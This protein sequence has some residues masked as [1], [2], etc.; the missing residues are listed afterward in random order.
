MKI[1]YRRYSRNRVPLYKNR[2]YGN[3]PVY[4]FSFCLAYNERKIELTNVN[5]NDDKDKRI[6]VPRPTYLCVST[7]PLGVP[8]E[9]EVYITMA[10]SSGEG[11]SSF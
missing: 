5:K 10:T 3:I 8:V 7:T 2:L 11:D 9:P 4:K 6:P 1:I